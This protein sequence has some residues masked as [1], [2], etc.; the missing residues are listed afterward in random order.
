MTDTLSAIDLTAAPCRPVR[1]G[2]VGVEIERR[3]DGWS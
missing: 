3:P 2:E 1:F